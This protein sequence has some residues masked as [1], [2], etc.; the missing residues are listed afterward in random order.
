MENKSLIPYILSDNIKIV[1]VILRGQFYLYK[2]NQ[3][4]QKGDYVLCP[5][6]SDTILGLVHETDVEIS[7]TE[8][9]EFKW[10][11]QKI[12][13]EP[14]EKLLNQEK[15]LIE[16]FLNVQKLKKRDALRASYAEFIDNNRKKLL[17]LRND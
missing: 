12:D 15:E 5:F 10:I 4:L 8:N 9:F 1:K 16:E 2:T 17:S 3:E 7:L 6:G 13:L 14:Y 11:I